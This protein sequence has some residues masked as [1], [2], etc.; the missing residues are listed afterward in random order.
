MKIST[1]ISS[2]S[3]TATESLGAI[4]WSIAPMRASS[5]GVTD[6]AGGGGALSS[7]LSLPKPPLPLRWEEESV[8]PPPRTSTPSIVAA[9]FPADEPLPPP[10]LF[11][12][13]ILLPWRSYSS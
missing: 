10:L 4:R 11:V 1:S 9:V 6:A 12:V 7:P 3:A 13:V 5:K 2:S 8:A